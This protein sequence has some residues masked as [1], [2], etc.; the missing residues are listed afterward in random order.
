MYGVEEVYC[1]DF[2]ENFQVGFGEGIVVGDVGVIDQYV[3]V[4]EVFY[5]Q[6]YGMFYCIGVGDVVVQVECFVVEVVVQVLDQVVQC[7]LVEVEDCQLC[8]GLG[9]MQCQCVIDVGIFII[10]QYYF[11]VVGLVVEYFVWYVIFFCL[12][13]CEFLC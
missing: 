2:V 11:V 8:I 10:D 3:D 12:K 6:C 1:Y 9:E 4:V 5:C 7:C 13:K